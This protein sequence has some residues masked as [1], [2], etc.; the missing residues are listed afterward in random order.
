MTDVE[1]DFQETKKGG[2]EITLEECQAASVPV[3]LLRAMLR[4]FAPLM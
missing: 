2:Q 3:R 1:R 4:L